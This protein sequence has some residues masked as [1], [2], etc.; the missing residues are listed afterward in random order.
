MHGT[1]SPA[2]RLEPFTGADFARLISWVPANVELVRWA[3]PIFDWPLDETQLERYLSLAGEEPPKHLVYR[4]L[5]PIDDG[6]V[7]HCELAGID[8]RNRSATLARV[9]VAPGARTR[10][11]GRA[12]VGEA[13]AVAFDDLRLHRVEL[14]VFD[15][16]EPALRCYESLGFVRE[17]VLRHA[18]LVDGAWWTTVCMSLLEDEWRAGLA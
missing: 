2:V 4:A 16:N 5:A 8:R 7:G 15:F 9:I 18:C 10:D 3:G 17:G 12:M 13:L 14:R 1:V 6:V 11:Y